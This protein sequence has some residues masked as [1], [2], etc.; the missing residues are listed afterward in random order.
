MQL[1]INEYNNIQNELFN[2]CANIKRVRNVN[3]FTNPF[4]Y[5]CETLNYYYVSIYINNCNMQFLNNGF[6]KLKVDDL[7]HIKIFHNSK[8]MK[9]LVNHSRIIIN[10]R[11][12]L[13]KLPCVHRRREFLGK[14]LN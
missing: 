9:K 7:T 5:K 11:K 14:L 12:I 13:W 3:K 4:K 6:N 10:S 1:I 2:S 8:N